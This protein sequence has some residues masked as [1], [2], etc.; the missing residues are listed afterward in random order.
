[1]L[2]GVHRVI[3]RLKRWWFAT[4]SGAIREPYLDD[5]LS[6]FVFRFNR[7]TSPHG[8]LF[9]RLVQQAVQIDAVPYDQIR[10][11]DPRL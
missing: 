4:Y 1:M 5:Y 8:L 6:E 7:R 3:R 9:Y 2:P 11:S 10:G